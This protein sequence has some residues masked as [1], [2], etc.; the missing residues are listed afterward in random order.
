MAGGKRSE[1]FFIED[2]IKC[3]GPGRGRKEKRG[4]RMVY[5]GEYSEPAEAGV[6][7]RQGSCGDV[8]K[9]WYGFMQPNVNITY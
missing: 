7:D 6:M 9:V 3:E 5:G 1:T 8:G 2:I 4:Q